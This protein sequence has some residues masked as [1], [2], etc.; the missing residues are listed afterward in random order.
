MART[1]W[2]GGFR[3]PMMVK[4]PGRIKPGQ[5][6]NGII[7]MKDWLPTLLAAARDSDKNTSN[8]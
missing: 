4:W 2:E 6:S 3:V 7:S 1:T 5:V 8:Q